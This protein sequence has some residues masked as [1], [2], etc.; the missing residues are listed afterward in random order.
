L[1]N[2]RD[3]YFIFLLGCTA[4]VALGLFMEVGEIWHDAKEA[5]CEKSLERK[6]W[7]KLS[8]DR[9]EYPA[10]VSRCKKLFA[11]VGWVLIVVGVVGEGVFEGVY[12]Y[13]LALSI[14]GDSSVAQLREKA[15]S[16]EFERVKIE[17]RVAFRHLTARQEQEI[18]ASLKP[19][20]S[21]QGVSPSSPMGDTESA[22]FA[23]DIAK[24][25]QAT[26]ALRVNAPGV[27]W[28]GMNGASSSQSY[29][30]LSTGVVVRVCAKCSQ[31]GSAASSNPRLGKAI[32]K[33]LTMRGF[34]ARELEDVLA[35]PEIL[36]EVNP[37]PEGPQ[38]E[39]KL[40]AEQEAQAKNATSSQ[41]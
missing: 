33:E 5:V 36:I 15:E 7:L 32:A 27:R 8:V 10:R 38:G 20:C 14:L 26:K 22:M 35:G 28:V 18:A 21:G 25:L 41:Q 6:H 1:K 3:L 31:L 11:A 39:Y 4:L 29:P 17:A 16:E 23:F 40:Q 13:D 19:L 12:K 30:P 24:A 2:L 9:K 34:D 37:H